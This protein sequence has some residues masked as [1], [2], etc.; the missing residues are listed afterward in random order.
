M[1]SLA[2]ERLALQKKS[3]KVQKKCKALTKVLVG[4]TVETSYA[5]TYTVT[6]HDESPSSITHPRR[7]YG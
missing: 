4:L 5:T 7:R 2:Q 3:K 6:A 1:K